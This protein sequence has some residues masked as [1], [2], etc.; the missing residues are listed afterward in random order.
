[1]ARRA[2]TS[3]TKNHSTMLPAIPARNLLVPSANGNPAASNA[4]AAHTAARK[5]AIPRTVVSLLCNSA[6]DSA[7]NKLAGTNPAKGPTL[8]I[9]AR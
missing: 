6:S 4:G 3:P 9:L 8:R 2:A 1:M 7:P 5:P